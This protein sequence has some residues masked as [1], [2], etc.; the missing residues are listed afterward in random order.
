[1]VSAAFARP[2]PAATNLP[3]GKFDGSLIHPD[4][5][6]VHFNDNGPGVMTLVLLPEYVASGAMCMDGTPAGFYFIK[7]N[8]TQD[9]YNWQIYFEGGGWCYSEADCWGRSKGT[10]GSS[11]NWPANLTADGLISGNCTINP[12]FCNYNRVYM[13]YCDGNSFSGDR[14]D[15]MIFEDDQVWFRGKSNIDAIFDYI[16]KNLNFGQAQKVLQTGC[17]AGGLATFLHADYVASKLPSTVTRYKAIPISGFFLDYNT[18][19]NLPVYR[20]EIKNV[21]R[22]SEPYLNQQ[23]MRYHSP[24]EQWRCNFASESYRFTQSPIF[25]INSFYDSWQTGCVLTAEYVPDY[26]LQNGRCG[27]AFGWHNCSGNPENCTDDQMGPLNSFA[28]SMVAQFDESQTSS[29]DGNGGFINSCHDHCEAQN[30]RAFTNIGI[31]GVSIQQAVSQWWNSNDEP[32]E[33]HWYYDCFYNGNSL[34][35]ACNPTCC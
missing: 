10:L 29:N 15:P 16:T 12:D 26:S 35:R 20:D 9:Q 18:V 1:V 33:K 7:A 30:N 14:D 6:D 2:R 34:P 25:P 31:S 19:E 24:E 21:F 5:R 23:C 27:D 11:T 3:T 22:M 8:S 4:L 17:S 32:A 28:Q 13:K